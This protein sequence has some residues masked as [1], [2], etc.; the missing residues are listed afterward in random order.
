LSIVVLHKEFKLR[1]PD[2]IAYNLLRLI[3]R[4]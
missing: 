3:L 2:Q 4:K 1:A